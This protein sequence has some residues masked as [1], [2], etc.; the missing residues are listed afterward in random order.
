MYIK[1]TSASLQ[2]SPRDRLLRYQEDAERAKRASAGAKKGPLAAKDI[3]EVRELARRRLKEEVE[4]I[5]S[6][7]FVSAS[8]YSSCGLSL[9]TDHG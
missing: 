2:I 5:E 4:S 8:Q 7:G 6:G 1:P 9:R 3:L